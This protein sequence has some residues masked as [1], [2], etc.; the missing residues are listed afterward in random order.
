M[1]V[2]LGVA[3]T[4]SLTWVGC[5]SS[6]KKQENH[7][8]SD[9]HS[10]ESETTPKRPISVSDAVL[11]ADADLNEVV[12][13]ALLNIAKGRET[14]DM[15]L[16]MNKGIMKLRAVNERDSNNEKAIYHLGLLSLESG[17]IEKAEKRFEK[18]VLLQPENQEYLKAL[19]DIRNKLG[20]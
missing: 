17:Q 9:T 19:S 2:V 5:N 13:T 7:A 6:T 18:L 20:K 1:I 10:P 15:G 14:G 4:F 11:P 3:L 12:E 16:V 8:H